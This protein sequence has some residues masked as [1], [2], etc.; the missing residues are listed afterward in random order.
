MEKFENAYF[1][2]GCFW[3]TQAVFT[4][5][6][7]VKEVI[8]GFAGGNKENPTYESVVSGTTGHAETIK[9]VF[10]P[11]LISYD[12]LLKVFWTVHNPASLNKQDYDVGKEYRS[13]IFYV[14]EVQKNQALASKRTL[15]EKRVY[16]D[17]IVTEISPLRAFYKAEEYHQDFYDKN[18]MSPYCLYI[19]DPKIE[20]LLEKFGSK[21]KLVNKL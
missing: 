8:T 11:A 13:A 17:P 1:A 5:L 14:D 16:K 18:K 9:I 10:D 6:Q 15:E 7:G 21:V 19:I 4:R 3:C 12:T 20:K 2:G